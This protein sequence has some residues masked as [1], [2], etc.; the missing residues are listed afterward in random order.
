VISHAPSF[1]G[2][3][4]ALW[5][6]L[7]LAV[8]VI[9]VRVDYVHAEQAEYSRVIFFETE[10]ILRHLQKSSTETGETFLLEANKLVGAYTEAIGADIV[11]QKAVYASPRIN[12]TEDFLRFADAQGKLVASRAIPAAK[13]RFVDAN[14]LFGALRGRGMR[15]E[16]EITKL[17]N[18]LVLG[19]AAAQGVD[20]VLQEAVW[21]NKVIDMTDEA[22]SRIQ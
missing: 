15:D 5:S 8:C 19:I 11:L 6:F 2:R 3:R 10:R 21:A 4:K 22:L 16:Q 1:L 7:A 18:Q 13:I 9:G 17:L 14:K 20:L 12:F